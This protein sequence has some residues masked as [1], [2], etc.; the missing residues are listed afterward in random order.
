MLD[1]DIW[2]EFYEANFLYNYFNQVPDTESSQIKEVIGRV[3][4]ET[5]HPIQLNIKVDIMEVLDD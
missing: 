4:L 5:F 1:R 2:Q 3:L